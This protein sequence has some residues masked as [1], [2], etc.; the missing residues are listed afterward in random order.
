[1]KASYDNERVRFHKL[2]NAS[3]DSDIKTEFQEH[4]LS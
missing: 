2:K 4:L 3:I 1:M